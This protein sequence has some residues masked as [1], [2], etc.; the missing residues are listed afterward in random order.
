MSKDLGIISMNH[1]LQ[2]RLGESD[3]RAIREQMQEDLLE[4]YAKL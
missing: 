1:A 2:A 4:Y 3:F